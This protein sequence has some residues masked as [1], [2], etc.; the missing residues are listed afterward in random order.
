MTLTDGEQSDVACMSKTVQSTEEGKR[1]KDDHEYSNPITPR[2]SPFRW[3][4]IGR[5]KVVIECSYNVRHKR[6]DDDEVAN[7]HLVVDV[8]R[9][10]CMTYLIDTPKHLMAMAASKKTAARGKVS[11]AIAKNDARRCGALTAHRDNK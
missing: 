2:E 1:H 5:S 7:A 10:G 9:G 11:S 3:V 4:R 8:T 6:L